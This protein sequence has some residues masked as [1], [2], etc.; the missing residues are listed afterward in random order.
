MPGAVE[1]ARRSERL[2]AQGDVVLR[3]KRP[4]LDAGA[5]RSGFDPVAL[6]EVASGVVQCVVVAVDVAQVD[7]G[8][9]DV[10][11][12]QAAAVEQP[13]RRGEHVRGLLE[14]IGARSVEL[15]VWSDV[16]SPRR[17][18]RAPERA[19]PTQGHA[20]SAATSRTLQASRRRGS[21]HRGREL[22]G[23][24]AAQGRLLDERGRSRAGR[25]ADVR[26]DAR[27]GVE[28]RAADRAGCRAGRA[29][30]T[31]LSANVACAAAS[32]SA[33]AR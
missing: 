4:A 22:E 5:G 26:Q 18:N 33:S 32:C 15:V 1:R 2:E 28:Q 11:E 17:T 24:A 8:A 20:G 3:R 31:R 23:G 29:S 30:P 14:G 13:F 27:P 10:A 21:H 12:S 9:D 6:E 16:W 19:Q 7:P 25:L